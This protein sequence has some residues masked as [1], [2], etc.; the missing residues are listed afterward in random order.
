MIFGGRH[1]EIDVEDYVYAVMSLYIDIVN[2]FLFIL[3]LLGL[4]GSE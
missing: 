2:M 4:C 1:D 3:A